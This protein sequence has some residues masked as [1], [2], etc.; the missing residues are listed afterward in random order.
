MTCLPAR[1]GTLA[2]TVPLLDCKAE[3]DHSDCSRS[4][5]DFTAPALGPGLG[6]C[7]DVGGLV[8]AG[9]VC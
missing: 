2:I 8:V 5:T 7:L 4:L 3:W 6:D 1:N 9:G